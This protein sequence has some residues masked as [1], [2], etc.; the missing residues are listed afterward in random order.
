M[1]NYIK[2]ILIIVGPT[3]IGK[4]DFAINLAQDINAEITIGID[5]VLYHRMTKISI[6]TTNS[7]IKD[8]N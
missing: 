4:S 1:N 6:D 3:G 7:L 8:F 2:S 5:H